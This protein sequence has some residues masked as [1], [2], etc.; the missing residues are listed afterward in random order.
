V[1]PVHKGEL[2]DAVGATG[3]GFTVT[4]VV[5]FALGHP[6]TVTFTE[7]VPLAATVAPAMEGF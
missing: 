7:Y 5:A 6:P 2:L 3:I 1:F 4:T